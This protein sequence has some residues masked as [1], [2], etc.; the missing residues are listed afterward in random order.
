MLNFYKSIL[1]YRDSI[2]PRCFSHY[3]SQLQGG[4]WILQDIT[5]VC[6]PLH[7]CKMLSFNNA[8]NL[9]CTFY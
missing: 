1:H 9:I 3:C 8:W 4:G 5:K 2:P 7:R 6:E